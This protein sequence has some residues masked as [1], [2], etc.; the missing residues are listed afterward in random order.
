MVGDHSKI[1]RT[2]N[3]DGLA[4][5]R[6]DL[7]ALGIAIGIPRAEDCPEGAGVKRQGRVQVRF[8]EQRPVREISPSIG[9]IGWLLVLNIQPGGIMAVRVDTIPCAKAGRAPG[10][11]KSAASTKQRSVVDVMVVSLSGLW[12]V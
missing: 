10:L 11:M 2:G 7:L 12:A 1:Q 8:A 5:V 6:H 3:A 4:G 9:R